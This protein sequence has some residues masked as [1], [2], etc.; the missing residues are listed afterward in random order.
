MRKGDS[1][2][3]FIEAYDEGEAISQF[4]TSNESELVSFQLLRGRESIATV[5][6]N[7]SVFLVRVYKE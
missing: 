1:E 5:R 4:V 6:K 3:T 2:Q 7:D